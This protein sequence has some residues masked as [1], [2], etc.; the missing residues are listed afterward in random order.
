M[1]AILQ[2]NNKMIITQTFQLEAVQSNFHSSG[3]RFVLIYR[4]D[5]FQSCTLFHEIHQ[6]NSKLKSFRKVE[7]GE[8]S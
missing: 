1:Q 5:S 4:L 7:T 2:T 6:Q 3:C 8:I